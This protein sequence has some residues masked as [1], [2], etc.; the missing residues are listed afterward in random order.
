MSNNFF[1]RRGFFGTAAATIVAGPLGLSGFVERPNA[2]T[3]V[4]E[5][6]L[7]S[8]PTVRPFDVKFPDTDLDE[9]RKR[10]K[11]TRC[12]DPEPV[13][14]SSQGVPLAM[15]QRLSTYW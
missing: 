2:I 12:P 6:T 13:A 14:D 15:I 8:R 10:I 4:A 3:E 1:N 11:A 9:L 7:K 5:Q